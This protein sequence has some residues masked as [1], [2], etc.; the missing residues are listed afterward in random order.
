M[1]V[2]VIGIDRTQRPGS[3]HNER[4]T[5]G[6]T[7]IV[8]T[9]SA[10]EDQSAIQSSG[11]VPVPGDFHPTQ[12]TLRMSGVECQPRSGLLWDYTPLYSNTYTQAE[13]DRATIPNPLER[14][15]VWH[16]VPQ[17][18]REIVD[19][20]IDDL[21]LTNTAGDVTFPLP[22]VPKTTAVFRGVKNV[23]GLPSW[24]TNLPDKLNS[25]SFFIQKYNYTFPPKTLLFQP[26]EDGDWMTEG[27]YDFFQLH[28]HLIYQES[29]QFE[30]VSA[31]FY[32][33]DSADGVRRRIMIDG[34]WATEQ[35]P[36]TEEGDLVDDPKN[37][38]A[39]IQ[40]SHI[41]KTRA[42]AGILA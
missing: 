5:K 17:H 37:E 34:H 2:S 19:K 27:G 25:D 13:Q 32:Y 8:K 35:R 39:F 29:W 9:T 26:G 16:L 3:S 40:K 36:L 21:A 15:I 4:T 6:V 24:Y 23:A 28:F 7:Y 41:I 31:G 12:S 33:I 14:P 1:T 11:L 42:F 10:S 30:R 20:D 18:E 22:D 38:A